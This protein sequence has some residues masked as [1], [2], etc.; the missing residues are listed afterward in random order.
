MFIVKTK[1]YP[2]NNHISKPL[3]NS[4]SGKT[5]AHSGYALRKE[6]KK[7]HELSNHRR[8]SYALLEAL[9]LLVTLFSILVLD[10][11]NYLVNYESIVTIVS[12]LMYF[13]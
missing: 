2:R 5:F 6:H 11:T 4:D 9:I 7:D 3:V 13:I 12:S 10:V 1:I 8:L